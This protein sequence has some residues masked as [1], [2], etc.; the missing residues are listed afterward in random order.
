MYV[1]V[2]QYLQLV[3]GLAP[4]R[5]GAWTVPL[6]LA[7]IAGSLLTP[8]LSRRVA[9]AVLLPAGLAVA[10]SGFA[11]LTRLEP[12]GGPV[13]ASAALTL[14]ALGLSPVFTLATDVMVGSVAPERAGAAAA[15]S[16]TSSELGGA[17]GIA[18]LGS[19]GTFAYRRAMEAAPLSATRDAASARRT[20]S[21]VLA[22]A[23]EL[24][25]PARTELVE[26]AHL[27]FTHSV[28]IA[29]G[30][31]TVITLVLALTTAVVLRRDRE[32]SR[33]AMNERAPS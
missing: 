16:E 12:H 5:A 28:R 1:F 19:I 33:L 13:L 3:L 14:F 23:R 30:I 29:A 2:A 7:F 11:L 24:D 32:P 21:A 9:L 6:A 18:L 27:A 15:L 31:A 10:A 26:S 22:A 25:G 4:L 20:L 8:I 17:L